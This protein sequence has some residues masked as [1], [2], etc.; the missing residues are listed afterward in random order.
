MS[1]P[2]T[3]RLESV[4]NFK[5]GLVDTLEMEFA[6]LKAA[7]QY[8]L[9]SLSRLEQIKNQQI[10]ALHQQQ[11]GM[12]DCYTIQLSHQYLDTLGNM[13]TQQAS[14]AEEIKRQMEAKREELVKSMQDQEA[15]EKLRKNHLT[16]RHRELHRREAQAVDDIVITR[17]ARET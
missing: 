9:N 12:L 15:L 2:N 1:G 14:R 6:Q 5:S 11:Q 8:E 10:D 16:Q 17:Y 13:V 4:L 3:F 7:H